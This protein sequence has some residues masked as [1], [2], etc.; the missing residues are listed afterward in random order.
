MSKN[1]LV[2]DLRR[3]ALTDEQRRVLHNAIHKA[4][5]AQ[6]KKI[7]ST[8]KKKKKPKKGVMKLA[9]EKAEVQTM[10]THLEVAFLATNPG[11]SKLTA[12]LNGQKQTITKSGTITL[13]NVESSDII[14][15]QG[16]SLG[17]TTVTIDISAEPM[18]MSFSPGSFNDNFFIN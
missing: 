5:T 3:I 16:E 17:M 13:T 18:Q 15:I 6:L 14:L 4:V 10:T 7:E 1:K 2:I 12:I 8:G 11:L 9:P